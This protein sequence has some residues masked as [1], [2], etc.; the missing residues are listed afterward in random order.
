MPAKF[1]RVLAGAPE[2]LVQAEHLGHRV[3]PDLPVAP[4]DMQVV[5]HR[6]SLFYSTNLEVQLRANGIE[7]IYCSGVS[8]QAVVFG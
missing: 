4:A 5:K 7:R 2:R 6:V 8:T 3:H 1:A